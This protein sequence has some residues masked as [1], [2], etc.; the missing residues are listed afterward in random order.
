MVCGW[1][2]DPTYR[3]YVHARGGV[4]ILAGGPRARA[5][6]AA[7][8]PPRPAKPTSRADRAP[9]ASRLWPTA[10]PAPPRATPWP[11]RVKKTRAAAAP[12]RA[13]AP[14]APPVSPA[15]DDAADA[16]A[17]DD[18]AQPGGEAVTPPSGGRGGAGCGAAGAR[19]AATATPGGGVWRYGRV[20]VHKAAVA[21]KTSGPA[22]ARTYTSRY[23]G[24]HQ[25]FPTK[26]WEAQ[27]RAAAHARAHIA[28]YDAFLLLSKPSSGGR[29]SPPAW[30][31]LTRRRRLRLRT[32]R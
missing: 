32:T 18:A 30:G 20:L 11:A 17:D 6:P 21:G 3:R 15:A 5:P 26:R 31:V 24:V 4:A 22:A 23:R 27:V 12:Q 10:P 8:P 19:A 7:A 16:A 13:L 14:P 28:C 9:A 25:T 2:S 29:A 1:P